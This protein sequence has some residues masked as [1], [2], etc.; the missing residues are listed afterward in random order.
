MKTLPIFLSLALIATAAFAQTPA[1]TPAP[2][3]NQSAI[4][5]F[6]ATLPGG[7]Y[8]VALR[9]IIAV[10]S[11]E[12]VVDGVARVTE[13]N[14]DTTGQLLARF[15]YLEPVKP[16][17]P[18]GVGNAALEQAERLAREALEKTGQ[19]AWKKVVK[20]YPT[21]THARTVE[22]RLE[23]KDQLN[24]LYTK[25]EEA[26]RMQRDTRVTIGEKSE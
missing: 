1:G 5:I 3:G 24:T 15:Y 23:T 12:Y 22:Y 25:A 20:N 9:A 18:L 19:D 11:H 13:V 4:P 10:T 17:T 14:V 2:S 8:E 16:N 26:F 7:T 6:R 21:T